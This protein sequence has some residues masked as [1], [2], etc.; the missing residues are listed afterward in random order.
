M[1]E[2]LANTGAGDRTSDIFAQIEMTDT[3]V[4]YLV[5]RCTASDCSTS[6]PLGGGRRTLGAV[7]PGSTHTLYI[8]WDGNDTFT[9]QLDAEPTGGFFAGAAGAPFFSMPIGAF[10]KQVGTRATGTANGS[11]TA[12]FDVVRCKNSASPNNKVTNLCPISKNYNYTITGNATTELPSGRSAV[13]V[14][15]G[16]VKEYFPF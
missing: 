15:G 7:S 2:P 14:N 1:I 6:T 3:A 16:G 8:E 12:T 5:S 13:V 11:I 4:T 9:F 10:N